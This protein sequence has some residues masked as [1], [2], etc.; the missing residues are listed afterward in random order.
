MHFS[1]LAAI[2]G[3]AV[4]CRSQ[5]TSFCKDDDCDECP[6]SL[7]TTGTGY[8]KC[9]IY[10]T[11]TVF[12]GLGFKEG[13]EKIEYLARGNFADPCGGGPGSFIVRSP[14]SIEAV[15]CGT[16]VFFTQKAQCS[17]ELLFKD[18]FSNYCPPITE[19]AGNANSR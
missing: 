4:L 1:R 8:P 16:V 14:A 17:S 3:V 6:T 2:L 10:D 19:K 12:G 13:K 7:A 9:V 15:G 5:D 18:T 11:E